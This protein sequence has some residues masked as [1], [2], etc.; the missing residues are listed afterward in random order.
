MGRSKKRTG[1]DA[2][3]ADDVAFNGAAEHGDIETIVAAPPE[4]EKVN[5]SQEIRDEAR[6]I[7]E[8]GGQPRPSAIVRSLAARGIEVAPAMVSAVLKRSGVRSRPRRAAARPA[9]PARAPAARQQAEVSEAFTLEQLI[10][11]KQFVESVGS[12]QRAMALLGALERLL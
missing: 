3:P 2:K 5:K 10:A 6:T 1:G 9:A 8:S 7:L 4:E 12:P 11:A